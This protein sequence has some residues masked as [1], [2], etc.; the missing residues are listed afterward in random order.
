MYKFISI[1]YFKILFIVNII[2]IINNPRVTRHAL[3]VTIKK[4]GEIMENT[5]KKKILLSGIQPS[6]NL[7]LGNY[8]GAIKN[9]LKLQEEYT[10]LYM[11]VDLHAL[12]VRQEPKE[13]RRRCIEF[14]AQ[15]MACGLD[16][17][18]N[19]LFLQSHVSGHSELAWILNC[20]TYMG[21]LSRMIQFKEKSQKHE[22]NI[23]AGLFTYP[24]LMAADILLYQA[25]MVPIGEDQKQHLEITRD[26]AMRFNNIYGEVFKIPEPFIPEVGARIMSLQDPAKKMSK[27]DDDPKSYIA[28]LDRPE[29]I[30]SK[31]KRAVTDT[32]KEV[33]Y[34]E[35]RPGISNLITIYSCLTG[36]SFDMIK[37]EY[38]GKGYADFKSDLGE[39][40][41]E[42]LK[43]VQ[44]R[45]TEL[46]KNRDYINQ[47]LKSGA[48]RA[49]RMAHRT[50]SK[51]QKKI[52]LI[53]I[54]DQ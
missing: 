22:T 23:N 9:W 42:Y 52:G 21:E 45:Y 6:G 3:C 13:L 2:K 54:S 53:Q 43:P 8:I 33:A 49:G 5:E 28:L 35:T 16:P 30:M 46:M 19:I 24:V 12:T 48:E 38:E 15:Y 25:D 32:G 31:I 29:I 7:A 47:S 20:Y 40:V 39:I 17:G 36:K 27:S 1:D 41:V 26:I 51:V 10:C 34:N 11:V 4:P 50:L 37:E 44:T 14:I 18:K